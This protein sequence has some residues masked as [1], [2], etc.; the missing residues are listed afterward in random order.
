MIT[1]LHSD[2]LTYIFSFLSK[3]EKELIRFVC[4][5]WRA[6]IIPNKLITTYD[7]A[8]DLNVLKWVYQKGCHLDLTITSGR[9]ASAGK[10]DVLEWLI[11]HGCEPNRWAMTSAVANGHLS[12]L[13]ELFK[14]GWTLHDQE[15]GSYAARH[16]HIHILEWALSQGK[17][18]I[19]DHIDPNF[20][21]SP[22]HQILNDAAS[23]GQ[24][25]TLKWLIDHDAPKS[26]SVCA[27]AVHSG[28]IEIIQYLMGAL[29]LNGSS[30]AQ[31]LNDPSKNYPLI[32]SCCSYAGLN[33]NLDILK[34]LR[35]QGCPWDNNTINQAARKGHTHIIEWARANGCD[36]D[37]GAYD[38]PID[39]G[40]FEMVKYL[41]VSGC[42]CNE[43][44]CGRAAYCGNLEI[45]QYLHSKGCPWDEDTIHSAH[46][47]GHTHIV[48][49]ALANGCPV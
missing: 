5:R 16:G 13:Q 22:Y 43:Y 39:D 23:T 44:T 2:I 24:L 35:D 17:L 34:W 49:W 29:N 47:G 14:R 48:E 31:D 26:E 19:R 20:G 36:W 33:G 46:E 12:V 1:T 41:C 4:P 18:C 30:K 7:Y 37:Y 11:Q 42:P 28:N 9:A 45:L 21:G 25:E 6:I 27:S 3:G 10:M 38:W 8:T 15:L 40:N 32:A